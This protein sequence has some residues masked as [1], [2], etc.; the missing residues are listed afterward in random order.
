MLTA[1][2]N[3]DKIIAKSY[4]IISAYLCYSF[5]L[6]VLFSK[7]NVYVDLFLKYFNSFWVISIFLLVYLTIPT[8]SFGFQ[9]KVLQAFVVVMNHCLLLL[10]LYANL[11]INLIL[12]ANLLIV[13]FSVTNSYITTLI[14]KYQQNN[15]Y[16]IAVIVLSLYPTLIGSFGRKVIEY[17]TP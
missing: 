4:L 13:V 16:K 2:I 8:I 1:L 11:G 9:N 15:P 3:K 6:V 12:I 7:T 14:E 17:I 5:F 10:Y